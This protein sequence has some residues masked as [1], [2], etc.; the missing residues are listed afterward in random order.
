[1]SFHLPWIELSRG[2]RDSARWS[3][4]SVHFR[5]NLP[6]LFLVGTST[7]AA[8]WLPFFPNAF[9]NGLLLFYSLLSIIQGETL[10]FKRCTFSFFLFFLLAAL[11]YIPPNGGNEK[12]PPRVIYYNSWSA[13]LSPLKSGD[14]KVTQVGWWMGCLWPII[15]RPTIKV[16]LISQLWLS[17]INADSIRPFDVQSCTPPWSQLVSLEWLMCIWIFLSRR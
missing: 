4:A 11:S 14:A 10:N 8:V 6:A 1:M 17:K 13:C 7:H 2:F 5:T 3:A 12:M 16:C 15:D 9:L